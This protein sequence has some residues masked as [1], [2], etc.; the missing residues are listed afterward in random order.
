MERSEIERLLLTSEGVET[1]AE[2]GRRL[3]SITDTEHDPT[4]PVTKIRPVGLSPASSR[5]TPEQVNANDLTNIR[6]RG[7]LADIGKYVPDLADKSPH[8]SLSILVDRYREEPSEANSFLVQDAINRL[9]HVGELDS[10]TTRLVSSAIEALA[11]VKLPGQEGSED[12]DSIF[13]SLFQDSDFKGRSLLTY[14]GPS[15]QYSSV[16]QSF[17]DNVDLNDRI[18]SLTLD[19]S[20]GEFR[21]DVILFQNDRFFGRFTQIRTNARTPT[22]QVSVEY[23]GSHINDQTSSLLLVRRYSDESSLALGNPII[24][25]AISSIVSNVEGIRNLRGDPTFTWDMWPEGGDDHPNDPNKQFVQV[26]I[27]VRINVSNWPDYDAEIW[28]WFYLYVGYGIR[29]NGT[30]RILPGYLDGYLAYYGCWVESGLISGSIADRIMGALPGHVGQI[31]AKL[32]EELSR[33]NMRAPYSGVYLLPGNQAG[34]DGVAYEGN[35]SD[36]VTVVLTKRPPS[37]VATSSY[38]GLV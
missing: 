31:D 1:L 27:P 6:R 21:G 10:T 14:L 37:D 15:S 11:S 30:P 17:L 25:S 24:N 5:A 16:R 26:K 28:L 4:R 32:D 35:V 22:L 34:F 7:L 12:K 36:N 18:S 3:S 8:K 9:T 33:V 20:A 29:H 2:N 38:I 13:S 19:A 23:V